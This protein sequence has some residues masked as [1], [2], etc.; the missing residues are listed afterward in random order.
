MFPV[1]VEAALRFVQRDRQ[2]MGPWGTFDAP[3][4]T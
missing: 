4:K 2:K 3:A 1:L